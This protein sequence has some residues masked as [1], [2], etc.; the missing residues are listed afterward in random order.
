MS[1][2]RKSRRQAR[3]SARQCVTA[4]VGGAAMV[5]VGLFVASPQ[6]PAGAATHAVEL[7]S[8]GSTMAPAPTAPEWWWLENQSNGRSLIGAGS[9]LNADALAIALPGQ[10]GSDPFSIFRP[11]GPGGWLIGN[12]IDAQAGCTGD[13]CN[14]GNAGLLFGRGGDGLNGGRGG[15]GGLFFGR[16]GDGGTGV[17][18]GVG[19]RG[20]NGGLFFGTGGDGGTGGA[21]AAGGAGQAG[22]RAGNG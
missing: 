1:R 11:I 16:G 3:I 18:G 13:A 4:G 15:D 10:L 12:G 6:T 14:G 5:G 20:G 7:T 9:D 17:T 19:G 2:H 21:G 8:F 22:G